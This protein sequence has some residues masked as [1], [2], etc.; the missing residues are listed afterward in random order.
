MPDL[1]FFTISVIIQREREGPCEILERISGLIRER[2]RLKGR[3][4][5]LSAEGRISAIVIICIPIFVACI[6]QLIQ[7]RYFDA[8]T[9]DPVGKTVIA[10]FL[11]LM[12]VGIFTMKKMIAIK[13]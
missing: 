10:A 8:L 1:K 13:I 5:T 4:K 7:P 11:I 3:I 12:I 2:F 6:L 9:T